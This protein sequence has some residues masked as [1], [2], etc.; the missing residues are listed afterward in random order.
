MDKI[1]RLVCRQADFKKI[2]FIGFFAVFMAVF[3][4][5]GTAQASF[6]DWLNLNK[7]NSNSQQSAATANAATLTAK[8]GSAL[9]RTSTSANLNGTINPKGE[10]VSVYF[11]YRKASES[12]DATKTTEW[13]STGSRSNDVT[14]SIKISGLSSG[15]EYVYRFYAYN[16]TSGKTINGDLKSFKT[17]SASTGSSSSAQSSSS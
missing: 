17:L 12:F 13:V 2:V 3:L 16:H 1:L 5:A 9:D 10:N 15:T 8:T 4:S 14:T 7:N 6:W 11:K